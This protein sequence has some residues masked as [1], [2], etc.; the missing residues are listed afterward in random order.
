MAGLLRFRG[1]IPQAK[2]TVV[3]AALILVGSLATESCPLVLGTGRDSSLNWGFPY[4]TM[5]FVLLPAA[6][7]GLLIFGL[8]GLIPSLRAHSRASVVTIL[9]A[10]LVPILFLA[11]SYFLPLP[12]LEVALHGSAVPPN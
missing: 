1:L 7:I 11:L 3:A 8:V 12:W 6:S 10:L 4:V 5:R 2:T 9:L